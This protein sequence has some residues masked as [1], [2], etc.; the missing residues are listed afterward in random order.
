MEC[1]YLHK[2]H[3]QHRLIYQRFTNVDLTFPS[4]EYNKSHN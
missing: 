1:H 3:P 2:K 4:D